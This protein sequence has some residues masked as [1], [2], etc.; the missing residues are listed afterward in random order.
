LGA[1]PL[2]QTATIG[3]ATTL[4]VGAAGGAPLS[5]QWRKNGSDLAGR[6]SAAL[7]LPSLSLAD[8]GDYVCVVSNAAG[9]ITTAGAALTVVPG[10]PANPPRLANLAVRAQVTSTPL[11]VGFAIG[12]A[13]TAGQKLLLVRGAGPALGALGV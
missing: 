8:A 12:G 7:S 2:R 1:S 10:E 11:I 5:Y 6:N 13:G 9:S 4:L 3:G